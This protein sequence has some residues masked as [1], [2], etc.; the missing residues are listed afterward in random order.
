M[1]I[2]NA[3]IPLVFRIV[4]VNTILLLITLKYHDN[5]GNIY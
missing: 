2:L 3:S 4:N 1:Y 5:Y